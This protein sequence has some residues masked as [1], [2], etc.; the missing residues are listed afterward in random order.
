MHRY[1]ATLSLSTPAGIIRCPH[2]GHAI[3]ADANSIFLTHALSSE[4]NRVFIHQESQELAR[5]R[6]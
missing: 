5:S 1:D 2:C 6:R 4:E 3:P